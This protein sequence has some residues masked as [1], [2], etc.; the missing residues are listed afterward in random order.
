MRFPTKLAIG[1]TAAL[2]LVTGSAAYAAI[3]DGGG[4]I[5]G[6]Y[7]SNAPAQGSLR[8]I[9]TA[10]NASCAANENAVTW[11]QQGPKGDPG[12][13]GAPGAKGEKGEKGDKGDPGTPGA[14]GASGLPTMYV[15]RIPQT[16]IP[17]GKY[18]DP[19]STIAQLSLPAGKYVVNVTGTVSNGADNVDA[20]CKLFQ[21]NTALNHAEFYSTDDQSEVFSVQETMSSGA[22]FIATFGC[23]GVNSDWN[24][25][26]TDFRMTAIEVQSIVD[27]S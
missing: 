26:L 16:D 23:V 5:H 27:E 19:P 24:W 8:V 9:D 6:C 13:P 1:A 17:G 25:I 22:P 18:G 10:K 15:K 3:P 4:V 21:G 11:N 7:K 2:A 12:T 20:D 14:P